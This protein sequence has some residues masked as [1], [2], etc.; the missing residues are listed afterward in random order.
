MT[1]VFIIL[2][3]FIFNDESQLFLFKPTFDKPN[4]PEKKKEDPAPVGLTAEETEIHRKLT[5]KIMKQAQNQKPAEDKTLEAADIS[6][7][8][9]LSYESLMS[10]F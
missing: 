6:S 9:T 2:L 7:E 3:A 10:R 4:K 8:I 5:E 1:I